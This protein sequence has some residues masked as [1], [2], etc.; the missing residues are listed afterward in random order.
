M[1]RRAVWVLVALV[2]VPPPLRGDGGTVCFRGRAGG[3]AV[4]AF[5]APTPLCAGPVDVSVLV[6]D[7]ESGQPLPN[8]QVVLDCTA[9]GQPPVH[10][11]ATRAAATNKLMSAALFELPAAGRWQ[12][13]VAIDGDRGRAE[14]HFDLEVGEPPPPWAE[15]W[16]WIAFPVVPVSFF[17]LHQAFVRR[18][19]QE[20]AK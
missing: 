19:A 1:N 14:A 15:L 16:P 3:Y 2:L 12:V 5:S 18:P 13:G 10:V 8:V 11:A 9:D 17:I 7:A 20:V 6:Q 4:T